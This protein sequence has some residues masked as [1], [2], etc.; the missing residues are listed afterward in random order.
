MHDFMFKAACRQWH[1]KF[2]DCVKEARAE[3]ASALRSYVEKQLVAWRRKHGELRRDVS[4]ASK[5]LI[6]AKQQEESARLKTRMLE[7][8]HAFMSGADLSTPKEND[9]SAGGDD[10][11]H[12]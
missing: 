7:H 9:G 12:E 6:E 5:A 2:R 4:D 8:L 11:Q 3:D 10:D 1:S